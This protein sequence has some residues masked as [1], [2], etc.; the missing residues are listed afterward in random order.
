MYFLDDKDRLMFFINGQII[1]HQSNKLLLEIPTETSLVYPS[2]N[3]FY[4]RYK[5]NNKLQVKFY[6]YQKNTQ[7]LSREF[8]IFCEQYCQQITAIFDNMILL[9]EKRNTADI[10]QLNINNS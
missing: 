3:G 7:S 4:Y 6:D 1:V 9:K 8:D 10:L 5:K 2:S